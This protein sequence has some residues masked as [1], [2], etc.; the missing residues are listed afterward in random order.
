[1][2]IIYI[3]IYLQPLSLHHILC[4]EPLP[5]NKQTFH[6]VIYTVSLELKNLKQAYISLIIIIAI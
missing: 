4:S 6:E 2:H 1:M 3:Y 5:G